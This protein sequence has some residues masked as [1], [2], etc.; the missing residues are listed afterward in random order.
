MRSQVRGCTHGRRNTHTEA[1]IGSKALQL[2]MLVAHGRV[3]ALDN[4]VLASVG[5]STAMGAG[6]VEPL[7]RIVQNVLHTKA[8]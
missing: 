6:L 4:G 5:C 1:R 8:T 3:F 2:Q 7:L